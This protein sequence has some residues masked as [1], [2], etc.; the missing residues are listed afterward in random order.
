MAT[1]ASISRLLGAHSP[2]SSERPA[3]GRGCYGSASALPNEAEIN[4]MDVAELRQAMIGFVRMQKTA[5][6]PPINDTCSPPS[7]YMSYTSASSLETSRD[8]PQEKH[9]HRGSSAS[10]HR[11]GI[12]LLLNASTISDRMDKGGQKSPAAYQ[13]PSPPTQARRSLSPAQAS[14]PPI[15]DGWQGKH[16]LPPISQLAGLRCDQA[17]E[18]TPPL[19]TPARSGF[20]SSTSLSSGPPTAPADSAFSM[21]TVDTPSLE[22]YRLG[23]VP[24]PL[25]SAH[26]FPPPLSATRAQPAAHHPSP[27][28]SHDNS[29][30]G[31]APTKPYCAASAGGMLPV[32]GPGYLLPPTSD[33]VVCPDLY[34]PP[35][36]A[37]SPVRSSHTRQFHPYPQQLS[38]TSPRAPYPPAHA[39]YGPRAP[40]PPRAQPMPPQP[41][42]MPTAPQHMPIHMA[43]PVVVRNV[44]KP[45]FNYA[46]LDTK[47]PRG[48]SSRWTP[49]EDELLKRA[50][51][52]FG[53]DRQWVK[54]AQ[55]V[56]GRT[57]LQCRQR[58]LCNIKAQVE[59][60]RCAAKQ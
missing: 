58:W 38:P 55:Q 25:G 15:E 49:H 19:Q 44:S 16:T 57:N 33:K 45:K 17:A 40:S 54:V 30:V 11:M 48:P 20:S 12:D 29:P 59:K 18:T 23:S 4:S 42:L 53:E 5:A 50:V 13:L 28:E 32:P 35:P 1:H 10:S 60:E 41:T 3:I 14:S 52:Q 9:R 2:P 8:A 21:G 31:V 37:R 22:A 47:R 34:H 56:P 43:P 26:S 24:K 39:C 7:P 27:P 6:T 51:K 46:F 36:G